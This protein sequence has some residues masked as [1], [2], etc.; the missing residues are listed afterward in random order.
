MVVDLFHR[1][2]L[3]Q[4]LFW[5]IVTVLLPLVEATNGMPHGMAAATT[6][7]AG[8]V[9]V[10]V[11]QAVDDSGTPGGR[12][13]RRRVAPKRAPTPA[14]RKYGAVVPS[15]AVPPTPC[16]STQ[17][18]DSDPTTAV[19]PTATATRGDLEDPDPTS[20]DSSFFSSLDTSTFG[21]LPPLLPEPVRKIFGP[22]V[23][24]RHPVFGMDPPTALGHLRLLTHEAGSRVFYGKGVGVDEFEVH[25]IDGPPR[26]GV[27]E[28]LA[29]VV[30]KINGAKPHEKPKAYATVEQGRPFLDAPIRP[31]AMALGVRKS[32]ACP[33][34][35]NL[36]EVGISFWRVAPNRFHV[37]IGEPKKHQDDKMDIG[38]K[39]T[40]S[41]Q[42]CYTQ[43]DEATGDVLFKKIIPGTFI[44][45]AGCDAIND[46]NRITENVCNERKLALI[47]LLKRLG[48]QSEA[49]AF[50]KRSSKQ[51]LGNILVC[52]SGH[53]A[54]IEM[55]EMTIDATNEEKKKDYVRK[56]MRDWVARQARGKAC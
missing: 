12:R 14:P 32:K 36:L 8:C 25:G 28:K 44:I 10:A 6:S 21:L 26:P 24:V 48:A 42:F 27:V 20:E 23:G 53:G 51:S 56:L 37:I 50:E 34:E 5:A 38:I 41:W 40:A 9:V 43:V 22:K 35:G 55:L 47:D 16:P 3:A 49:C 7:V 52:A 4:Y 30:H 1:V 33:D 19:R 15:S 11:A 54:S 13:K 17:A 29:I 39:R 45:C 18:N 46:R 31:K 2:C